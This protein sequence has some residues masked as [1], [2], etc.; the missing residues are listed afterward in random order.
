MPGRTPGRIYRR[1]HEQPN[2]AADEPRVATAIG[3][4][5][6]IAFGDDPDGPLIDRGA[7]RPDLHRRVEVAEL[8][9][10]RD[11]LVRVPGLDDVARRLRISRSAHP[12]GSARPLH[13]HVEPLDLDRIAFAH[14]GRER[15]GIGG[16]AL[17]DLRRGSCRGRPPTAWHRPTR[18]AARGRPRAPRRCSARSAAARRRR[19]PSGELGLDEEVDAFAVRP[20]V[21]L[22]PEL[23]DILRGQRSDDVVA[24]G[25]LAR[26]ARRPCAPRGRASRGFPGAA[27]SGRACRRG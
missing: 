22:E 23:L 26:R 10:R 1:P 19:F 5:A 18:P 4:Q 3:D 27:A 2:R 11:W 24:V 8:Q 17:G 13:R 21:G 20:V 7:G 6:G 15:I 9:R 14:L 16:N 12:S 25:E